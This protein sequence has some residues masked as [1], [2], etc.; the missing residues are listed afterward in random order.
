MEK[1]ATVL[2]INKLEND[3]KL[4]PLVLLIIIIIPG[5]SLENIERPYILGMLKR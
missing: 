3:Y 2:D 5:T 4:G 1:L